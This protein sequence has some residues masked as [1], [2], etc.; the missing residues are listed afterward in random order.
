[1]GALLLPAHSAKYARLLQS[2]RDILGDTEI[3]KK[4]WLLIDAGD[5]EFAGF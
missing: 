3:R 4:R 2:Q 5:T 1:M